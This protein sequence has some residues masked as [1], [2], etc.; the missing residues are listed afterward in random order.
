MK[1]LE[2]YPQIEGQLDQTVSALQGISQE[3]FDWKPVQH[4]KVR[5]IGDMM[6]R[7]NASQPMR[8]AAPN[9]VDAGRTIR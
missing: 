2:K 1:A 3:E 5:S 4:E 9:S 6:R 8:N 7:D